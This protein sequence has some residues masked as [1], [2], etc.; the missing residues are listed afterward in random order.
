MRKIS[1]RGFPHKGFISTVLF[2]ND[3]GTQRERYDVEVNMI[4][5]DTLIWWSHA[6][7]EVAFGWYHI[8]IGGYG[9]KP[10][11]KIYNG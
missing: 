4:F 7:E 10:I 9:V 8:D 2:T 5:D 1:Q 3:K 11:Q 6:E